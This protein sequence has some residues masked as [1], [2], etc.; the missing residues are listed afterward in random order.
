MVVGSHRLDH[1]EA[2]RLVADRAVDKA[3]E[4]QHQ[5]FLVARSSDVELLPASRLV[6]VVDNSGVEAAADMVAEPVV[7]KLAG[8]VADLELV[9]VGS[10]ALPLGRREFQLETSAGCEDCSKLD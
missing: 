10:L 6:G 9:A 4:A 7:D 5:N 1:I 8:K 2:A 3:V